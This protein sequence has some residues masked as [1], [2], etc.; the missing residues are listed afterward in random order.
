[1]K[2]RQALNDIQW[3]KAEDK[4]HWLVKVN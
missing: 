1:M 3:G 2:L 4:H